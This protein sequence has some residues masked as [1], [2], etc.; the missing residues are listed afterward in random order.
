MTDERIPIEQRPF[1]GD[2]FKTASSA[3]P[4]AP[5][6]GTG[7]AH[8]VAAATSGLHLVEPLPAQEVEETTDPTA[9]FPSRREQRRASTDRLVVAD[10]SNPDAID[11]PLV[12]R[13]VKELTIDTERERTRAD[14]DVAAADGPE[15]ELE[16]EAFEE[17]R[18]ITNRYLQYEVVSKLGPDFDWS[19]QHKA[20]HNLAVFDSAFRYGRLQQYLREP[21]IEDVSIVGYDNVMVTRENGKKE[22]RPNAAE[23]NKDLEDIV[24]SIAQWRGRQYSRPNGHLDPDIGGARLSATGPSITSVPNVTLRKHNHVDIELRDLIESKTITPRMAGFLTACVRS[25]RSAL[26]AGWTA[27]GKTTFL[28]AWMSAVDPAEKIV[29]IET[30]HELYLNKL[31]HRH[32]QVQD[33]QYLPSNAA[34]EDLVSTFSL[35][36]AFRLSLRSSAQMILFGEIRGAEGPIA[37]KA[38]QAGKGSVSTIHARN[39]DDAIHRFADILMTVQRLTDDTAPLRQIMRSID[40]IVHVDFAFNEDGTRRRIVTEIAEVQQHMETRMPVA[41]PLFRWN[42]STGRYDTPEKPT[43]ELQAALVRGGLD[44]D[45]FWEQ[46]A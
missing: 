44:P 12:N 10:R 9:G 25:N 15:T 32:H 29:T 5:R 26:V 2:L 33:L 40:I 34:G 31:P 22:R 37:I 27:A 13:H 39:A 23:N 14:F 4:P 41:V 46:G 45:F 17:I 3:T 21:G 18:A 42:P 1:F 19:E 16:R 28:R 8:L 35:E 11:W 7:N 38:M 6:A 43:A 20:A 36:D 24:A 30:E